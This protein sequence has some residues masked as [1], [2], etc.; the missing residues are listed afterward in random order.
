MFTIA[1]GQVLRRRSRC[2]ALDL[3]SLSFELFE[4][5]SFELVYGRADDEIVHCFEYPVITIE[6]TSPA[7]YCNKQTIVLRLRRKST[8]DDF[9]ECALKYDSFIYLDREKIYPGSIINAQ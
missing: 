2:R 4:Y 6:M 9:N 5:T 7:R 1:F 3:K 8:A